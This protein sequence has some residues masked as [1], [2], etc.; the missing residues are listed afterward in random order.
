MFLISVIT[1]KDLV[2]HYINTNLTETFGINGE[3]WAQGEHY[4]N[5]L[6]SSLC[7][8]TIQ[9]LFYNAHKTHSGPS[10]EHPQISPD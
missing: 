7:A 10:P 8:C 5:V 3:L 2:N 9:V 1:F 6:S 4:V